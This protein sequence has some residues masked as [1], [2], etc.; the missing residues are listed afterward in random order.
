MRRRGPGPA[1]LVVLTLVAF[2]AGGGGFYL[3]WTALANSQQRLA[4]VRADLRPE[5]AVRRDLDASEA[6]LAESQARLQH[7]ESSV[8]ARNYVPTLLSELEHLGKAKGLTVTGVRPKEEPKA[9]ASRD[10]RE[11][12]G[13]KTGYEELIV[14]VKGSGTFAAVYAFVASLER[15]PKIVAI[16]SMD[17][18]PK[19]GA[20]EAERGQLEM[21]LEMRAFLFPPERPDSDKPD[22]QQKDSEQK[23]TPAADE[24]TADSEPSHEAG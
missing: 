11:K 13:R 5:S 21:T 8:A 1:I 6:K 16:R 20:T 4:K 19:R 17:L 12:P 22:S 24:R 2:V 14:E 10:R 15:F 3:G 18:A 23:D 9:A 7:L